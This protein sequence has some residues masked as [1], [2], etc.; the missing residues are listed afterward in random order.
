MTGSFDD[1]RDI[2]QT[3]LWAEYFK[4][5]HQ[6]D[7]DL[8]YGKGHHPDRPA[9]LSDEVAEQFAIR[10]VRDAKAGNPIQHP[11]LGMNLA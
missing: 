2:A 7:L 10:A 1:L 6:G 11:P 3:R 5:A 4:R 9:P 8:F